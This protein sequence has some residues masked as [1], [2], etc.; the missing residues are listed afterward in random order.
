MTGGSFLV[1]FYGWFVFSE[2]YLNCIQF[3][4]II[5]L[6]EEVGD[7][8]GTI[9]VTTLGD[10]GCR[11]SVG[12]S[13]PNETYKPKKAVCFPSSTRRA[14]TKEAFAIDVSESLMLKASGFNVPK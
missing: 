2:E 12:E 8:A 14:H 6:G 1:V 9:S 5:Q 13:G 4:N 11:S 3:D 10:A 7:A